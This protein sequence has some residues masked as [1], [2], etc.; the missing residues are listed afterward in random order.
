MFAAT[1]TPN[2]HRTLLPAISAG[3]L[4]SA[5]LHVA[6]FYALSRVNFDRPA[7]RVMSAGTVLTLAPDPVAPDRVDTPREPDTTK[8]IPDPTQR[9]TPAPLP[10]P[11]PPPPP[12]PPTP[13][14][15]RD[16]LP[17][18]D[19]STAITKA[20]LGF[21]EETPHAMMPGT[22]EQSSL[23]PD[24]GAPVPP[25]P[26]TPPDTTPNAQPVEKPTLANNPATSPSPPAPQPSPAANQPSAATPQPTQPQPP[27]PEE[28]KTDRKPEPDAARANDTNA[29]PG[30]ERL[31][32]PTPNNDSITRPG[33]DV[34]EQPAGD[35]APAPKRDRA[36]QSPP[37]P[38]PPPPTQLPALQ[39]E[40][41][42]PTS[43]SPDPATTATPA[44]T[45]STPADTSPTGPARD[46]AAP[47]V[48]PGTPKVGDRP[49]LKS[50][51]EADGT[52]ISKAAP[53]RFI[54]GQIRARKGL[55]VATVRPRFS[56]TTQVLGLA[57]N[58]FVRIKFRRDGTVK[59]VE[60]LDNG[61]F[62]SDRGTGNPSVDGPL[63]FALYAWTAKGEE[64]NKL[65]GRDDT[66]DMVIKIIFRDEPEDSAE[67]P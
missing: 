34:P 5:T 37:P 65:Q 52:S 50:Q 63:K 40:P 60:F 66:A 67:E 38:P 11:T 20:W 26:T 9:P 27:K 46:K 22:F 16:I 56:L 47:P 21:L 28:Q 24:P 59:D 1:Y 51:S 17:G 23:S 35:T 43:T 33:P 53:Y 58:T 14:T 44:P 55:Q 3:L 6:I 64:L 45:P 49:A 32:P 30:P 31:V 13:D 4:L 36:P 61:G 15:S 42:E 7:S 41:A 12:T 48:N 19:G 18:I 25:G 57:R 62:P 8:R 10:S 39:T 29:K 2:K 54:A